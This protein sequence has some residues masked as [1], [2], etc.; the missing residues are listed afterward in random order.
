MNKYQE[1]SKSVEKIRDELSSIRIKKSIQT[2]FIKFCKEY[3]AFIV[4]KLW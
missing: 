3:W 1:W 2:N 4:I